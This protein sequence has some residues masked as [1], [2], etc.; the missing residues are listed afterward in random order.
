[1]NAA[2]RAWLDLVG[3]R[4]R[5]RLLRGRGVTDIQA[6]R[7][8]LVRRLAPGKSWIDVGG[9]WGIHGAMAFEAEAAGATEVVLFDGMDPS[10]EFEAEH[11]RRSS[12]IRYVQGDLHDPDGIGEL[13]TFD[14]VWCTGVLY[15][16]P[17]PYWQVEQLRRLTGERL[18]VGSRVIPELPGFPQACLFYPGLADAARRTLPEEVGRES[19]LTT[20]FDRSP[21]LGYANWWW[22][23]TPSALRAMLDAA[24]FRVD[25]DLP[26]SPFLTRFLATPVD[27]GSTIPPLDFSRRRGAERLA[28]RDERPGWA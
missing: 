20:P 10:D 6:D 9:M 22:G 8:A 28:E 24:N 15:H 7:R 4:Q 16:S 11:A 12:A 23:I 18:L 2:V 17:N 1:M 3:L 21:L 19:G 27:R 13:G 5:A 25:Q 26:E 14:V